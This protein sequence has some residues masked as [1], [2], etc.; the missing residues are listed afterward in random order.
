M[1]AASIARQPEITRSVSR[2]FNERYLRADLLSQLHAQF[3][4]EG[5]AKLPAAL[6]SPVFAKIQQACED[7]LETKSTFKNFVMPGCET[8]RRLRAVRGEHLMGYSALTEFYESDEVQTVVGETVGTRL[9]AC[10][11]SSEQ[12][13][14]NS[15]EGAG[16]THGAHLDDPQV[17]LLVTIRAPAADQGGL[18]RFIP[19]WSAVCSHRNWNAKGPLTELIALA[20]AEGL[21]RAA[22][23]EAGD[24]YI[25]HA[26]NVL[27]WVTP[28]T[29]EGVHRVAL[30][31]AYQTTQ[32]VEYGESAK[33]LYGFPD[34]MSS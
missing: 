22:H 16:H 9:Y 1:N 24:V 8:P 33:L 10:T 34:Q 13:V 20:E 28:L 18:L 15:L 30:N 6:L 32:F 19:N 14:L 4:L 31:L 23:H 21:V 5:Y 25:L 3:V 2:V 12:M 17:A 27:H 7:A 29:C 11:L 26:S